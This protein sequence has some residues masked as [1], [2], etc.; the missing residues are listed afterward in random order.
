MDLPVGMLSQL[1]SEQDAGEFAGMIDL[2]PVAWCLLGADLRLILANRRCA[3]L[4]GKAAEECRGGELA[5]LAPDLFCR[6]QPMLR[7][8]LVGGTA[9]AVEVPAKLLPAPGPDETLLVTLQGHPG[10]GDGA[11]VI[12]LAFQPLPGPAAEARA[13]SEQARRD[14]EDH[15]R[16]LV[17]HSPHIAWTA[18]PAGCILTID[19]RGLAGL[20]MSLRE[21]REGGWAAAVHPQDRAVVLPAWEQALRTGEPYDIEYRIRLGNGGWRWIRARAAARHDVEGRIIRWYGSA[22]DIDRRKRTEQALRESEEHYRHTIELSPQIPWTA[23]SD[24]NILE[25]GPRWLAVMGMTRNETLG[26]GW[27]KALHPNDVAGTAKLWAHSLRTGEPVDVEY[28]L[29]LADGS[30]RWFRARAAARRDEGGRI[31]RWYGTVEDVQ[32]RKLAEQALRESEKFSRQILEATPDEVK[33]LDPQ[34]RLIFQNG[35][36][37]PRFGAE[38]GSGAGGALWEA[39]WPQEERPRIRA[40]LA[41]AAGGGHVSFTASRPA[42]TGEVEWW[43]NIVCPIPDGG[44]GPERLLVLS[45]DVTEARRGQRAVE[46]ARAEAQAAAARLSGVLESTTDSVVVIDRHWQVTYLNAQAAALPLDE[47]LR[48][49]TNLWEAFPDEVGGPFDRNYRRALAEQ[50]PVAFEEQLTAHGLWLEVHAYPTAEGGL[51]IFFRDITEQR[52]AHQEQLLV[53]QRLAHMARHDALTDLPNRTLFQ[54][55]LDQALGDVAHGERVA[56][57][58]LDLDG[59]KAV[60]DTLGHPAGDELLREIARRLKQH[61]READTVARLGGDEFA[62]VQAGPAGRADAALLGQRLLE[63]LAEPMELAGQCIA[64]SASIGIALAP[65]HGSDAD[66]LLKAADLALYRAKFDG[67]GMQRFYEAGMDQ[68]L[69]A[70]QALKMELRRALAQGELELAYQPLLDLRAAR[71]AGFEALLRWRHPKRGLIPP[72]EFIPVAEE[73]GLIVPI[74]EW[75]LHEACREAAGWPD[76]VGVAVNLSPLQFRKPGLVDAVGAA[77]AASGLDASRLELEITESVLLHHSEGNLSQLHELRG[78]GVRIAMDDFGTGYSSLGYLRSFP[79][80]KIKIDRSFTSDL[81]DGIQSLAIIQAVTALGRNL[82]IVTLAEGVE[83]RQQ[84][85]IL[86]A[87]GCDMAQ[88]Y[89]FGRPVSAQHVGRVLLLDHRLAEQS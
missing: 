70:R 53:Q 89:L 6:L 71:V 33:V 56:V 21:A 3:A 54:E 77:L 39:G 10:P 14:E 22:S 48:A 82:G 87:Q 2:V 61:V 58:C 81:P 88:G 55:R 50:V 67:R 66:G 60:N 83:T 23:D 86:E 38:G 43:D 80:D 68:P 40:A 73:T 76:G 46:A 35:T 63:A 34:G 1:R 37:F 85:A 75:V 31:L 84:L 9:H 36:G 13:Q 44:A 12:A 24:G 72:A 15:Y 4:L 17:Q 28:R 52:R 29:R 42:A 65:E 7:H 30:Y 5:G 74:G 20:G 79:F 78:L 8:S 51:S 57:H 26:S 49:G 62:I 19:G 11:P 69:Q 18:D 64:V 25:V 45:R 16:Y 27:L 47:K 32:D 41:D 59:L